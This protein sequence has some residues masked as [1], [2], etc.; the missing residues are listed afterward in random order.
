MPTAQLLIVGQHVRQARG[1]RKKMPH[2]HAPLAA[3]TELGNVLGHGII[4]A[5]EPLFY[6]AHHG[7]SRYRLGD[8]GNQ[9]KGLSPYG[10]R[11]GLEPLTP[12][13]ARRQRDA[14]SCDPHRRAGNLPTGR[15][16]IKQ[17]PEPLQRLRA[18]ADLAGIRR[19]AHR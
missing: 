14:A 4:E 17:P 7:G 12:K 13:V 19:R 11:L 6:Q 3:G 16:L 10:R 15:R 9:E 18:Q 8:R 5:N 2:T 1:V